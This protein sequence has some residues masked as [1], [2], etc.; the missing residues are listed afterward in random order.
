MIYSLD[1]TGIQTKHRPS[2]VITGVSASKA[3]T[4][5][6]PN[7]GTSTII[8][9]VNGAGTAIPPYNVF[10]GKRLNDN[11]MTNAVDGA[12]YAIIEK[13]IPRLRGKAVT[14]DAIHSHTIYYDKE[15]NRQGLPK[16]LQNKSK[17]SSIAKAVQIPNEHSESF[18]KE[19]K[20][21]RL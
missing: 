19:I 21:Y 6:S 13:M 14:K 20:V 8:A 1:E 7:T 11:L 16:L 10:T 3:Q 2:L 9:W 5:T 4:V 15:N 18:E 17:S 12:G